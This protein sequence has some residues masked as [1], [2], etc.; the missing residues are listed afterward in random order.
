MDFG[1][2][3]KLSPR[4]IDL[5]AILDRIKEV[6]YRLAVPSV[7]FGVHN[8]FHVSILRKYILDPGHGEL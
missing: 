3:S 6:V 1:V 4:Y 7:L 2:R 5:F 8:V